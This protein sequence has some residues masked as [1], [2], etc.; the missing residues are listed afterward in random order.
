MTKELQT[1]SVRK[2][3][4]FV[5]VLTRLLVTPEGFA[6]PASAVPGEG[7]AGIFLALGVHR[8]GYV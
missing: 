3:A 5:L 2:Q 4:S 7:F 8:P 6:S 1:S